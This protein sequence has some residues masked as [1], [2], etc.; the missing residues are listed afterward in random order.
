MIFLYI[1]YFCHR[2]CTLFHLALTALAFSH[3]ITFC[4]PCFA[5]EQESLDEVERSGSCPTS[6][7]LVLPA[8]HLLFAKDYIGMTLT[9]GQTFLHLTAA[10]RLD[11]QDFFY[12]DI[13]VP[14]LR[15]AL[16][17]ALNPYAIL[18]NKKICS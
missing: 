17:P 8:R 10:G 3:L 4:T 1:A 9:S 2:H 15:N 11:T 12:R 6:R 16:R 18:K 14:R 5:Y 7:A 13:V